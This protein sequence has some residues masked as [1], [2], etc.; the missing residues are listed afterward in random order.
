[1][2]RKNKLRIAIAI[3]SIVIGINMANAVMQCQC[4]KGDMKVSSGGGTLTMSCTGG[5]HI[6]CTL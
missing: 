1:M 6:Q 4:S 2:K 5:G 3:G